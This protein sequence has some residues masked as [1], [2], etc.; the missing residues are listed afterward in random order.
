M[1]RSLT[2]HTL[3]ANYLFD[4]ILMYDTCHAS[5]PNPTA[6]RPN[7][8]QPYSMRPTLLQPYSLRHTCVAYCLACLLFRRCPFHVISHPQRPPSRY[9]RHQA[10]TNQCFPP[11][12]PRCEFQSPRPLSHLAPVGLPSLSDVGRNKLVFPV[13]KRVNCP[14][15]RVSEGVHARTH[16]SWQSEGPVEHEARRG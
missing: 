10:A 14:S 13:G 9:S 7:L 6:T 5:D 2:T 3:S 11:P 16:P 1:Y 4:P 15:H 12:E 8:L